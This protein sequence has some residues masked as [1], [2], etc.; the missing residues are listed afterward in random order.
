MKHLIYLILLLPIVIT[1]QPTLTTVQA[2]HDTT[3]EW[4]DG[5]NTFQVTLLDSGFERTEPLDG[6]TFFLIYKMIDNLGNVIYETRPSVISYNGNLPFGGILGANDEPVSNLY[7]QIEDRTDSN[8]ENGINGMLE[9]I[10]IPCQGLG[11]SPKI[12]W[13][14]TRAKD[15][16]GLTDSP[17]DYN[18]PTDI[19]LTKVN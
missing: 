19:I 14:I 4:T 9:I 12:S 15:M 11:C 10:Y 5:T 7:G 17:D 16:I 18:L 8:Y 6:L 2:F 13:K 3:W 1:A